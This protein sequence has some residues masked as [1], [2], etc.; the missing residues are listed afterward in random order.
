MHRHKSSDEHRQAAAL[1][2]PK[3]CQGSQ[4][5]RY[6][7]TLQTTATLQATGYRL[8]ATGYR[9]QAA[10]YRLRVARAVLGRGDEADKAQRLGAVVD[11]LVL[12]VGGDEQYVTRSERVVA[13][14]RPGNTGAAED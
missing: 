8:Q 6:A 13:L 14:I 11:E 3:R 5:F 1:V 12:F 2:K 9:L 4:P 10:G 7:H